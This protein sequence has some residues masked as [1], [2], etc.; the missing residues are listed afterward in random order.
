MNQ[1]Q[2]LAVQVYSL[3][4]LCGMVTIAPVITVAVLI[5]A[6]HGSI[7]TAVNRHDR[8]VRLLTFSRETRRH[9]C[10]LPVYMHL[11]HVYSN[12]LAQQGRQSMNVRTSGAV[13]LA[14]P[15]WAM[16]HIR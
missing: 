8:H 7:G 12:I 4:K 16:P 9:P 1:V 3:M 13:L 2:S 5:P 15:T 11:V 6:C 10:P 14:M